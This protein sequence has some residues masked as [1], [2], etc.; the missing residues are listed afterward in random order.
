MSWGFWPQGM[1]NL[2]SP[3][4]DQT[5]TP[6]MERR[7]LTPLGRQGSLLF[8]SVRDCIYSFASGCAGS[9]LMSEGLSLVAASRG[10]S[11]AVLCGHL[12]VG[13]SLFGDHQVSGE[14]ASVLVLSG[15][16]SAS[17]RVFLLDQRWN[18]CALPWRVKS[19]PQDCQE[20]SYSWF[21]S[22]QSLSRVQLL[23][24]TWAAAR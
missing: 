3:S 1:W 11:R 9:L 7:S 18:P 17:A 20:S 23:V 6:C 12:T 14:G 24:T 21:S 19:Q 16:S 8:L 2:S 5:C 10:C 15:L 22:V 4:R 13:A